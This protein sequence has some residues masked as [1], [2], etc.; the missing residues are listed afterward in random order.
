MSTKGQTPK[1]DMKKTEAT[2]S[3]SKGGAD[4]SKKMPPKK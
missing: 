3:S 1:K 4:K 2:K